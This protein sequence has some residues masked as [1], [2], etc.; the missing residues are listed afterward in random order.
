MGESMKDLSI[1]IPF[2][3]EYPQA[4]FTVQAIAQ[5]LLGKLDF[6]IIVVNNYCKELEDQWIVAKQRSIGKLNSNPDGFTMEEYNNA[7][8]SMPNMSNKS[9]EAFKVSEKGNKWLKYMEFDGR[10]SHWEC[11]R[12]AVEQAQSDIFLF[13]DAHTI[14]SAGIDKMYNEYRWNQEDYY[15][16]GS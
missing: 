13:V 1:I 10:L 15:R 7:L 11:K 9:A 6:E 16:K 3:G 4:I 8:N 14:P 5:S 2:A 12:L